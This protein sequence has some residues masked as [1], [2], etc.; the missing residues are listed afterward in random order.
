MFITL[1]TVYFQLEFLYK[2]DLLIFTA[3]SKT[4]RNFK[5]LNLA[6]LHRESLEITLTVPLI[7]YFIMSTWWSGLDSTRGDIYWPW[8]I[9]VTKDS[10]HQA[11]WSATNLTNQYWIKI[12]FIICQHSEFLNMTYKNGFFLQIVSPAILHS[13][14]WL[15]K[16]IQ[17]DNTRF[18]GTKP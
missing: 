15:Y 3:G 17:N 18:K 8:N 1:K 7:F 2:S 13:P 9:I 5:T 6:S 4:F 16:A 12:S 14:F 10:S 11:P